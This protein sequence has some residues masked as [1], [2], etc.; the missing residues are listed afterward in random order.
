[1]TLDEAIADLKQRIL[2]VSPAA[3]LRVIRASDEEASIRAY[4]KAG[5]EAAI[6]DATREPTFELLTNNGL[7]VQVI[8]YDIDTSLPPDE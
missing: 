2:S 1:M 7:D 4:A 3:V 5:D 6:K 8:F